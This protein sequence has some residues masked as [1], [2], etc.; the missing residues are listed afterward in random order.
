[1]KK[2]LYILLS[3]SFLL[4]FFPAKGQASSVTGK[5]LVAYASQF[6]NI[7]YKFGGTTIEGFDC[8]GFLLFVF[9]HF[10]LSLPRTSES[11]YAVGTAVTEAELQPGDLVFFSNTYKEGISHSGIYVG[12][13]KFISATSDGVLTVS[14]DNSYWSKHYTGAKRVL[15]TA[16]DKQAQVSAFLDVAA[17]HFA[18]DAVI[19]LTSTGIVNGFPDQTFRPSESVTRGQAAAIINRILNHK[20][21]KL[22][23]FSDVNAKNTFAKD[24]AAI[25]EL[26][27]INGF[28][29]GTFRPN[30]KLTRAQMAVI[31]K[32]AFNIKMTGVESASAKSVYKD[33]PQTYWAYDAI[34]TMNSI[35]RTGGF[36]TQYYRVNDYA[37][38]ADFTA[39]VYNGLHVK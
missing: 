8:S 27:V 13:N 31:V 2:L 16:N 9:N 32:N 17:N 37:T 3:V 39:A 35:D 28:P 23:Y 14:M 22:E 26:G 36:Q 5:E 12:D 10:G 24:I 20:P 29:D 15:N 4:P 6:E 34:A 19:Q 30:E 11:Q 33:V 25:K 7:P 1:M 21:K 18:F 38:R